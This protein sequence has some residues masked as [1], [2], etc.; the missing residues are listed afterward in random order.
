ME[1]NKHMSKRNFIL[2]III[3]VITGIIGTGF[4]YFRETTPSILNDSNG[5]TNFISQFNPFGNTTKTSTDESSTTDISLPSGQDGE[6]DKIKLI[7]ISSMPIAGYTAFTKERMTEANPSP[8]LPLTGQGENL[9]PPAKGGSGGL[10]EFIPNLR[11]VEKATG[12]VYQTFVDK[13]Y[14]QKFSKTIIPKVYDAYFGNNGETVVLRYLKTDNKTIETFYGILPKEY[15]GAD[16]N[17]INEMTGSFLPENIKDIS[18]SPDKTKVFYLFKSNNNIIGTTLDFLNNKKVQIFDSPFTEWSSQWGNSKTISLTT[19]PSANVLGYMY[20]IDNTGNNLNRILGA[21]EGLTTLS[22][23]DDKWV[24]YGDDDLTLN[25]YNKNTRNSN[26]L[27]IRTLPEKCIWG[28][29]SDVL[30]CS[31]PKSIITTNYPDSWYQ[32]EISFNDQFWK[33]DTQTGN[34]SL[35]LNPTTITTEEIDGIKLSLDTNENYL[36]FVNKKDSFLWGLGLK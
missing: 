30:Y 8:A 6:I 5:G 25:I 23:P 28:G 29:A 9:V 3:L 16:P 1:D 10:T 35:I 36:F 19:K 12:N 20:A 15:L 18:V 22:S 21:I 31:V 32:G 14:E 13:I 27:G 33:I 7:K 11:Y 26:T 4:L 34:A 17:A 24:L 2:L